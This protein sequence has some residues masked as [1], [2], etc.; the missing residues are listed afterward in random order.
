MSHKHVTFIDLPYMM[1]CRRESLR[2]HLSRGNV[3]KHVIFSFGGGRFIRDSFSSEI[4]KIKNIIFV[5][6]FSSL[7]GYNFYDVKVVFEK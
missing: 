4:F 1:F 3:M 7:I 5:K 2:G 6:F